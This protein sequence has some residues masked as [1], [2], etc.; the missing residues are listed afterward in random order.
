MKAERKMV[1]SHNTSITFFFRQTNAFPTLLLYRDGKKVTKY[2]GSRS[3]E[4]LLQFVAKHLP[5]SKTTEDEAKTV[6]EE[7]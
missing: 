3:L 1:C 4:D 2:A 5:D 7:L 6:K